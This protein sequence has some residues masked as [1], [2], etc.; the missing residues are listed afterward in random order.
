MKRAIFELNEKPN[1][2]P[3]RIFNYKRTSRIILNEIERR[4]RMQLT[5]ITKPVIKTGLVRTVEE[6]KEILGQARKNSQLWER[7]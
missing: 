4:E 5:K 3:K 6:M 1:P 7:V 2:R